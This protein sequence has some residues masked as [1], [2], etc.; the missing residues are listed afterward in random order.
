[1]TTSSKMI[2]PAKIPV[3][4]FKKLSGSSEDRKVALQ[5]LDEAF[6]SFGFIYLSN[7]TIPKEMVDEAFSW[8]A[9]PFVH[10]S[11][12]SLLIMDCSLN[13]SLSYPWRLSD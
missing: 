13:V 7:Y 10:F 12:F 3:V 1:M 4:D 8:V 5:Q 2:E 9:S 11:M 6:K